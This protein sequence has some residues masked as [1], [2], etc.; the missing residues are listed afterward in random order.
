MT[1]TDSSAG[2]GSVASALVHALRGGGGQHHRP[3]DAT[4][5]QPSLATPAADDAS[6][7]LTSRHTSSA[8]S[9]SPGPNGS[10]ASSRQPQDQHPQLCESISI[11]ATS[12]KDYSPPPPATLRA[13]HGLYASYAMA[14]W[15]WRGWEFI[16]ALVLIELYP[17]SLAVVA[18]YG[19][20]DDLVRVFFG[21]SVGEYLDRRW[22]A[23]GVPAGG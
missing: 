11:A 8:T 21:A 3:D 6:P 17:D 14:A 20:M 5:C 19:L 18:A 10:A 12:A 16:V 23:A 9:S 4:P 13:V 1:Q 22:V 7:T 15:A 2:T